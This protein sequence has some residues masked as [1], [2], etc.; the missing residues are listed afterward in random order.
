M[1]EHETTSPGPF[2]TLQERSTSQ[3]RARPP[4]ITIMGPE[5][6]IPLRADKSMKRASKVGLRSIFGKS[7]AAKEVEEPPSLREGSRS[8]GL[9]ASLAEIN[10]TYKLHSSRSEAS[11]FSTLSMGPRPSTAD[12][13]NPSP[14]R[15]GGANKDKPLPPTPPKVRAAAT[16]WEAPPLFQVYPQ[17]VKHATLP[18]CNAPVEALLRLGEMRNSLAVNND[19]NISSPNL[20]DQVDENGPERKAEGGKKRDRLTRHK[21]ALEWGQKTYVLVTSGYLL[22]YSSEGNFDRPPEK[23]L[24]L[25]KDSAA[26]ASDLIPGR[27]WVLQVAAFTDADGKPY[28]DT[29]SLKSRLSLRASEKRPVSN[30]LLVFESAESMD[31]WLAILRREIE[32]LGGRKKLSETGKPDQDERTAETEAE[33]SHRNLVVRDPDRFSKVILEDF[34]YNQEHALLDPTEQEF[35]GPKRESTSEST[36][37]DGSTTSLASSDGM[38]LES[39]RNGENNNRL[40]YI[41]SGQRTIVSNGSSPACSPT[42]ASFGRDI[43]DVQGPP[44]AQEVRLRPN[45]AAISHRRQS[46]QTMIPGLDSAVDG[47]TPQSTIHESGHQLA[48]TPQV[49]PNFSIPHAANLR[50]SSLNAASTTTS[51]HHSQSPEQ[52]NGAKSSRRKPPTALPMARPLSVVVDQPSPRSPC[53]RNSMSSMTTISHSLSSRALEKPESLSQHKAALLKRFSSPP[54]SHAVDALR[55][56][57]SLD[58]SRNLYQVPRSASSMGFHGSSGRYLSTAAEE[59]PSFKRSTFIAERSPRT[60][61]YTY[62]NGKERSSQRIEEPIRSPASA[63]SPRR[64]SSSLKG[65]TQSLGVDAQNKALLARRSM[66]QLAE[67][68]PPAPPPNCALPPIPKKH[69]ATLQSIRA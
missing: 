16:Y 43:E 29:K 52:E 67:G 59:L 36:L 19:Q 35:I 18:A 26:F 47:H 46:M 44:S 17:A 27:H 68:P 8:A 48:P 2:E 14:S 38:R 9:R 28:L 40:S 1:S 39:L 51:T 42:R 49:V 30:M 20:L 10:W 34:S 11:L 54:P 56:H 62:I 50:L 7:R 4:D 23:I 41:S 58:D 13:L 37:D 61:R 12:L 5:N 53:S 6:R 65:S 31:D 57:S 33:P 32:S 3:R 63:C 55:E 64:S 24:Q 22:Q 15:L 45:A 66:P 21:N 25:T 69:S 60:S